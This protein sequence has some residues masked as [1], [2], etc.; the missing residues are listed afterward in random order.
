MAS[1]T[2]RLKMTTRM[3]NLRRLQQKSPKAFRIAMERAAVQFLTWAN[4]GSAKESR[5]PPI[6]WGVLRGS[7]SAFVGDKLVSRF[8][9]E[10][11][12][13]K[14]PT[15]ATSHNAPDTKMTFVWNTDYAKKM[16]EHK[17]GWGPFTEQDADAGNQWLLKHLKA[18][19]NDLMKMIGIEF[20][21]ETGL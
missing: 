10:V 12:G 4:T 9:Q 1:I 7:S 15:P 16:H 5:K 8:Q 14:T 17:G 20:K 11:R 13:G 3:N 19:R 6:R 2:G 21:K 18:D